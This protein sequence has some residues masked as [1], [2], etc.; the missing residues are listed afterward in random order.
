MKNTFQYESSSI[1]TYFNFRRVHVGLIHHHQNVRLVRLRCRFRIILDVESARQGGATGVA[2]YL[3]RRR[4]WCGEALEDDKKNAGT[5]VI[6][7]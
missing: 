6:D 2:Q 3:V 5:R 7:G 1:N 4:T